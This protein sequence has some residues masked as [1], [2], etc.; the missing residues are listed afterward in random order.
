VLASAGNAKSRSGTKT[1]NPSIE[2]TAYG[3]RSCRTLAVMSEVR[4]V[5]WRG[6]VLAAIGVVVMQLIFA[7][8][9]QPF[10]PLA[11]TALWV[12]GCVAFLGG[13]LGF[14]DSVRAVRG[15]ALRGKDK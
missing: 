6:T 11:K 1:Q 4:R 8:V 2:R 9:E 15:G 12:F 5:R 3:R 13:G 10:G 7:F 14:F